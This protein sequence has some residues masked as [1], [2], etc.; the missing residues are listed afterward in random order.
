LRAQ[1]TREGKLT[2]EQFDLLDK[3]AKETVL[4]AVKFAENSPQPSLD[5][6]YDYTYANVSMEPDSSGPA[7]AQSE[8]ARSPNKDL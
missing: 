3:R 6:L 1:L 7:R 2:N 4:A 8:Q 5:K